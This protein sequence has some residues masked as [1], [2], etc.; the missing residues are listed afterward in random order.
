MRLRGGSVLLGPVLLI[1]PLAADHLVALVEDRA[2]GALMGD[3]VQLG[4]IERKRLGV[5]PGGRC[6]RRPPKET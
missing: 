4:Q 5:K 1:A 6:P 3:A 2:V